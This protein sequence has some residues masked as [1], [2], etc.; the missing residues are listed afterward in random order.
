MRR[1]VR[2]LRLGDYHAS[3]VSVPT[4]KIHGHEHDEL[5]DQL[6]KIGRAREVTDTGLVSE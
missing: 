4:K 3:Y 5:V 6:P 1:S 2:R